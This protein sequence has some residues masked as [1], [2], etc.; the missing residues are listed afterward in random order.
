MCREYT[1][2]MGSLIAK[3][4]KEWIFSATG[5]L[6]IVKLSGKSSF[7]IIRKYYIASAKR[8]SL[9]FTF[10]KWLTSLSQKFLLFC[11]V[12]SAS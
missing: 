7:W 6:I 11:S 5:S 2:S 4:S 8:T 10:F 12:S 1:D 9:N 3:I